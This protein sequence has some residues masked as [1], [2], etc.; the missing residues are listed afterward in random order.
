[1]KTERLTKNVFVKTETR[2]CNPGYVVTSEGVVLIDA[3]GDPAY[4]EE[5]AK[6]IAKL[7]KI[8]YIINTE[9]HF[10]HNMTNGF[11]DAPVIAS[12]TTKALIPTNT[13]RWMR[14]ATKQLYAEP[15][16]VPSPEKY[17]K[18]WPSITF[19]DRMTLCLGK[20]TFQIMLLPGHTAGQTAVYIPEEKV[21]FA[22]D[23][24]SASGVIG[25][26]HD[27]LPY[28]WQESLEFLE[29]L[30]VRCIQTGHGDLL[31][32]NIRSCLDQLS[33]SLRERV[34]AVEKFK[35]EGIR[36]REAAELYEKMF[37][38]KPPPASEGFAP[39]G[40]GRSRFA[41]AHLYQVIGGN[42]GY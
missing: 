39:R 3:P 18:G 13:D 1:M 9:Y 10:D 6:E 37:P 27:A 38:E 34:E 24:V 12:D 8:R 7:G 40:A 22:S 16:T 20:H 36:V 28:K 31:T 23:N 4:V 26:L 25:G 14:Q 11:F 21:V 17:Q 41:L 29:T 32:S 30:D 5:Y 42:T 35:A 2:G 19:S 15:F 33:S